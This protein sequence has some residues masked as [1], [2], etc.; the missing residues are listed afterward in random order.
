M[1][2]THRQTFYL[3]GVLAG[4]GHLAASGPKFMK[5]AGQQAQREDV[6]E[7]SRR[8]MANME[9][10]L[11]GVCRKLPNGGDHETRKY[12]AQ[13]LTEAA[14]RGETTLGGF[15]AIGRDALR[16]LPKHAPK[17]G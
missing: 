4:F 9:V 13:R 11:E 17:A 10:V 1:H 15:Q 6:M 5:P 8:T 7:L 12:I 14:E 3:M 16:E 2:G